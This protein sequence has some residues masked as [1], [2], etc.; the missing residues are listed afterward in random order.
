MRICCILIFVLLIGL[1]GCSSPHDPVVPDQ[2]AATMNETVHAVTPQ[3]DLFAG[4]IRLDVDPAALHAELQ[5][6]RIA[7]AQPPQNL[8][9]DLDLDAFLSPSSLVLAGI[10]LQQDGD[11]VIRLRHHHPFAA[12]DPAEPVTARNRADL[13]YS[14][15]LLVLADT[16]TESADAGGMTYTF[17]PVSLQNPDGYAFT[18]DLLN[19]TGLGANL[20]PYKLVVDEALDNRVEQ[21]NEGD[22]TGNY[23]APGGGWQRPNLGANG[24]NWTGYGVLHAGQSSVIELSLAREAL[25]AGAISFNLA[26]LIRYADPRGGV[27]RDFW[28]PAEPADTAAFAYRMPHGALDIGAIHGC[29]DIYLN[30]DATTTA[31]LEFHLQDWDTQATEAADGDLS[32]ESDVSLIRPGA[33][34]APNVELNVDAVANPSTLSLQNAGATGHP[35]EELRFTG[36]IANDLGASPGEYW[37]LI[38]ATDPEDPDAEAGSYRFGM[39]P[40]ALEP[41]PARALPIQTFLPLRVTVQPGD[42]WL[43]IFGESYDELFIGIPAGF[44][45]NDSQFFASSSLIE[46]DFDFLNGRC[47]QTSHPDTQFFTFST[48]LQGNLLWAREW[49]DAE[50]VGRNQRAAL[51][52]AGN[53]YVSVW[54]F[55]FDETEYPVDLDPTDGTNVRNISNDDVALISLDSEGNYRWSVVWDGVSPLV[56][57]MDVDDDKVVLS[58]GFDES[59]DIDPGPGEIFLNEPTSFFG[60]AAVALDSGDGGYLWHGQ[61]NSFSTAQIDLSIPNRSLFVGFFGSNV[62]FDPGGGMQIRDADQNGAF[63]LELDGAGNYVA[64]RVWDG[65]AGDKAESLAVRS[66]RILISGDFQS[67]VDFDPGPGE[68]FLTSNG[69]SDAFVSSFDTTLNW[70]WAIGFGGTGSEGTGTRVHNHIGD[71]FILVTP[72]T[73]TLDFDP[74]PDTVERTPQSM[75]GDSGVSFFSSDG[76]FNDLVVFGGPGQ[77]FGAISLKPGPESN[78][79]IAGAFNE[80]F[81]FDPGPGEYVRS[82]EVGPKDVYLQRLNPDGTF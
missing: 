58:L 34:G 10:E 82:A 19:T 29:N 22:P 30:E 79:Y 46:G 55:G 70:N 16:L 20:F 4:Q 13:S 80:P 43:R 54:F 50:L 74:G 59:F 2:E 8:L 33:G 64:D 11:L 3:G 81:D 5:F 69:S 72:F 47:D 41:D 9:Y 23:F 24:D 18:G 63:I 61:W 45:I 21:T 75:F 57:A 27:D 38:V 6:P 35:G 78:L 39:D 60:H 7:G 66:D 51:D 62:D 36:S 44:E 52:S 65:P 71:D 26:L 14:G 53:Y 42:N 28:L 15:R 73:D 31:A 68:T 76:T 1:S 40:I 12:P 37:G 17:D 48:D 32:D 67:M 77:D 49:Q 25:D 56:D